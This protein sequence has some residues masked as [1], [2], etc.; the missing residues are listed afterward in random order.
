MGARVT[1]HLFE[2]RHWVAMPVD[3][4]LIP[5]LPA[6]FN[7]DTIVRDRSPFEADNIAGFAPIALVPAYGKFHGRVLR[8][9]IRWIKPTI[10]RRKLVARSA[11]LR[12]DKTRGS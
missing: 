9:R 6:H 7:R 11:L 5:C 4:D 2:L 12:Q 3:K 1:R 10:S 8:F